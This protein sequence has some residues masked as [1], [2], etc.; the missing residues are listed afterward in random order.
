MLKLT[1]E[2]NL[3]RLQVFGDLKMVIE[4]EKGN[5][6]MNHFALSPL[7]DQIKQTA[8]QFQPINFQHIYMEHKSAVDELSKVMS[9]ANQGRTWIWLV[10]F[11]LSF[12]LLLYHDSSSHISSVD[13]FC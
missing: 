8:S 7:I 10:Y 12:C 13:G 1:T 9:V 4:W 5:F 11:P 2:N 3:D 6:R